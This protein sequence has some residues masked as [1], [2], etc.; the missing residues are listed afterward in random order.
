[1][2]SGAVDGRRL[3]LV[4]GLHNRAPTEEAPA[5]SR[6]E[7]AAAPRTPEA[8]GLGVV[9]VGSFNPAIFHPEWFLRQGIVTEADANEAKLQDVSPEVTI[10]QL[11]DM[12]L[13]CVSDRFSLSTRNISVA[14]RMQDF[15]RQLFRVLLHTPIRACGINPHV[16]L[17][18][19]DEKYWHKIGHTLAPKEPVW[20]EL[21]GSTGM[22][23]LTV[24]APRPPSEYPGFINITV[25]P[26]VKHHPG[27]FVKANYHFGLE[28]GPIHAGSAARVLKFIDSEWKQAS[29]I[30]R[31]TA[32]TIFEKIKPDHESS[33]RKITDKSVKKQLKQM[34]KDPRNKAL[35]NTGYQPKHRFDDPGRFKGAAAIAVVGSLLLSAGNENFAKDYI[36]YMDAA[37]RGDTPGMDLNAGLLGD[38]VRNCGLPPSFA[39]R[40]AMELAP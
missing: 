7:H 8:E 26:S 12:L 11:S 14:P 18:A 37:R 24:K 17:R 4:S 40:I 31:R 9:L 10:L 23:S 6:S 19:A 27:L 33:G 32:E 39:D 34:L 28:P 36:D 25:E 5:H 29:E 22:Q 20:N 21:L 2:N 15:I 13:Q 35:Y 38:H 16:H 30:A 1:L 3:E